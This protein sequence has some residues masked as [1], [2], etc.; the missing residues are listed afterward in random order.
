MP[1]RRQRRHT[2]PRYLANAFFLHLPFLTE[3]A[4]VY[5]PSDFGF[6]ILDFGLTGTGAFELVAFVLQSKIQN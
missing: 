6:W 1:S 3:P 4:K 2:G 5:K